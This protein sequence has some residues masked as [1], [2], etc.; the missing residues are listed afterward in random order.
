MR[1]KRIIALHYIRTVVVVVTV[2]AIDGIDVLEKG[3]A[4]R[5]NGSKCDFSNHQRGPAERQNKR[6]AS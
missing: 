4:N 2:V 6:R 3:P 1:C 5:S